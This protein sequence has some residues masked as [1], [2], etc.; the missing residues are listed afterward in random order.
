[1]VIPLFLW[2]RG[3]IGQPMFYISGYFEEYRDEYYAVLRASLATATGRRGVASSSRRSRHRP[4]R[5]WPRQR[6][7]S[8]FTER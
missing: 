1:M 6:P 5:T 8:S 7:S 4:R 3:M 2:Q